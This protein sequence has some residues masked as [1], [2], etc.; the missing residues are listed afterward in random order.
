[1]IKQLSLL[2][3]A[4]LSLSLSAFAE[5]P[6]ITLGGEDLT[7]DTLFHATV[8]PG[9]TQT[10]LHLTGTYPLDV[11]YLTIDKTTPGVSMHVICPGGKIAGTMRPSK[12][13]EQASDSTRLFF[14]GTNGD[15]YYTSGTATDG[16]SLVGTPTYSAACDGE[17]YKSSGS[18]YQ[19]FVQADGSAEICRLSWST[20]T[21]TNAAGESVSMKG[22]N[23]GASNNAVTLYT[24]RGWSS[25]CQGDYAGSCAE[26]TAKLTD[27]SSYDVHGLISLEVTSTATST[28]DTPTPADGCVLIARGTAVDFI[29][30]LQIG[31]TVTIDQVITTPDSRRVRPVQI[32]SGNPKNV[33]N[34]A[35]LNSESE[36]GDASDRHP[37]TA[38]GISEDGNTIIQ[39]V[40]DGRSASKGVTT[41]M[42]ADL[43]LRAGAYEAVNLDGGGSST[44]YTAAL[45]VRNNCSDGSE[46]SVG[47][48]IFAVYEGAAVTDT[49]IAR[50]E[51]A[52]YRFD[53]PE[54][55]LYTPQVLAFNAAGLVVNSDFK[56]YTLSAPSSLGEVINDGKTLR[57]SGNTN[58][59]LTASY[60]DATAA[61]M[62][63]YISDQL[64][65]LALESVTL[66][67]KDTYTIELHTTV[68][69]RTESVDPASYSWTSSDVAVATVDESGTIHPVADGTC[70]VTGIRGEHSLTITVNVE[71]APAPLIPVEEDF[72]KWEVKKTLL[73]SVSATE[74]EHGMSLDYTMNSS[75]RSPKIT[76]NDRKT[77]PS[78]PD[79]FQIR[80][81]GATVKPKQMTLIFQTA[82]STQPVTLTYTDFAEDGSATWLVPLKDYVDADAPGTYPIEF[83]SLSFTPNDPASANGHIDV[84]GIE[85]SYAESFSGVDAPIITPTEGNGTWYSID[86]IAL[87]AEPTEPGLYINNGT[88]V[89]V[90]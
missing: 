28:G 2:A 82:D 43:M 25:P 5:K 13:A 70:S 35:N 78:R 72:S 1:M 26:V 76:L 12:M 22:I 75:V 39:M 86:G 64:P 74:L 8:G 69:N 71:S 65:W 57:V 68:F 44:L 79:G 63:I 67:S 73:A 21:I 89:I 14:A 16:K 46:R 31:D 4:A 47:N 90:K 56:D 80:V 24:P 61:T 15:F 34:G 18:G 55:V 62:P 59:I 37:R 23:V 41:G 6:Y 42:L 19:F 52:D 36:R 54:M 66:D 53:A 50:L 7:I 38:I 40:V 84:P 32:V 3:A 87:P 77:L 83:V 10:Q 81:T 11:F 27:G 30:N 58:G 88:K 29:N 49:V 51:F 85:V 60:G 48:A 45:G 9:T 20:G 33:G 17:T